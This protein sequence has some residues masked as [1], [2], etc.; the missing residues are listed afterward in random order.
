MAQEHR[1]TQRT[2]H[3]AAFSLTNCAF[4]TN[5]ANCCNDASSSRMA[6]SVHCAGELVCH[7]DAGAGSCGAARVVRLG[8][9]AIRRVIS[10]GCAWPQRQVTPTPAIGA[11]HLSTGF[12]AFGAAANPRLESRRNPANPL[13]RGHLTGAHLTGRMAAN[14]TVLM[15][16]GSTC[17]G[18]VTAVG[19]VHPYNVGPTMKSTT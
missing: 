6:T 4:R 2:Q 16:V 10:S 5:S 17:R 9:A 15:R 18:Q 12:R 3:G 11:L 13:C 1:R 14:D 7:F 19:A 8:T